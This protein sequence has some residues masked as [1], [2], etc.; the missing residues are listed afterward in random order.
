MNTASDTLDPTSVLLLF[1][2]G[3]DSATLLAWALDTFERVETIGF[4]YGQ[5][6]HIEMEARQNVR[7]AISG[8]KPGWAGKIGPDQVVDLSGYGEIS[9]SALTRDR[10]IEMAESGLPNTFVPARNL[11]FL[12]VAGGYAYRRGID[13][14]AAGMC[15]TDFSGYPDCREDT[16][17]AQERALALGLDRPIKLHTPL[18]EMTKGETWSFAERLGGT[19]LVEMIAEHSH[20][21]YLGER[22][23]RRVW[24]YGCGTCPAC[25]LRAKGWADYQD[26]L[27]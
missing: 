2:G 7:K 11:V 19:D 22:G 23:E 26:Q 1:S 4:A 25:D 10:A 5:R 18:M 15:Q 24:G 20:T 3:Q 6:H 16:L 9:D 13:T 8:L 17:Q 12:A 14:L 27:A 21:C